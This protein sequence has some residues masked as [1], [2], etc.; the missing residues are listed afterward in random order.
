MLNNIDDTN[1]GTSHT[2]ITKQHLTKLSQGNHYLFSSYFSQMNVILIKK[3]NSR[4][5][6]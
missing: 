3:M 1:N 6:T 2:C 4:D 5:S